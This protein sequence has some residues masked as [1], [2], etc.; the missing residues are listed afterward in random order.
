MPTQSLD[1]DADIHDVLYSYQPTVLLTSDHQ[2][3]L[4][5]LDWGD[6]S[7]YKKRRC[8]RVGIT[9]SLEE[10]DNTPL[11]TRMEW[12]KKH[13]LIFTTHFEMMLM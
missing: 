6:I 7:F 8:L 11:I 1:R 9:A 3:Y 2:S 12:A 5:R 13:G 4:D 10:Y